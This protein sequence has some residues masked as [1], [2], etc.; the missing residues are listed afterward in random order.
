[1]YAAND[2]GITTLTDYDCGCPGQNASYICTV[3]GGLITV[4][5]GTAFSC[6]GRNEITLRHN[7]FER[8]IGECN[9]GAIVGYSVANVED[10][11]TSRLDVALSADLQ[12]QTITC[13][14]DDGISGVTPLGTETLNVT[15]PSGM[16]Q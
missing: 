5:A 2:T 6:A 10:C 1:M 7:S 12:G 13:S 3:V 14:V 9:F 11:Y 8:A 4:W 16:S 15:T